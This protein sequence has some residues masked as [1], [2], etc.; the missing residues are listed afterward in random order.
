MAASRSSFLENAA[1][2]MFARSPSTSAHLSSESLA[3][4][5]LIRDKETSGDKAVC[6]SCGTIALEAWKPLPVTAVVRQASRRISNTA[7]PSRR[8]AVRRCV[9]CGKLSKLQLEA[10]QKPGRSKKLELTQPRP[11]KKALSPAPTS[12]AHPDQE[13]KLS[14][15]KRARARKDREGLRELLNKSNL[16]TSK[17]TLG[18]L[19]FMKP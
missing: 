2:Y 11:I 5:S 7:R 8:I 10:R 13:T 16:G 14:S 17:S 1:R 18:L 9:A 4:T 6:Q 15:K 3:L 12:S 19:D